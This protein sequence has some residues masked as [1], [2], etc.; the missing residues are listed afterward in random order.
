MPAR[1]AN[2]PEAPIE[3]MVSEAADALEKLAV[4]VEKLPMKERADMLPEI[5]RAIAEAL[6]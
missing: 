1:K 6:K 2:A 3:D 5:I 4:N